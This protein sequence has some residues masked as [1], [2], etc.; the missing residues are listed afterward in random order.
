VE[1]SGKIN[2]H[3]PNISQP[4]LSASVKELEDELGILLFDR[5]NK[6][7]ALTDAGREFLDYAKRVVSQYEIME[8]RYL[9]K[10]AGK[11]RS[12]PRSLSASSKRSA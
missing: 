7:I 8:D 4:A 5:T 9:S 10:D 11:E 6:G 3:L 12:S 2:L 1:G